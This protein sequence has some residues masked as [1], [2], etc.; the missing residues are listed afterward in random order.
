MLAVNVSDCFWY[1]N[2]QINGRKA[3]VATTV[4]VVIIV[5]VTGCVL[6]VFTMR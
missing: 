2:T 5:I 1:Q 6:Y 4:V 3:V